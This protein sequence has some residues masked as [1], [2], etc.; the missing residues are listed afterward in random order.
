MPV[1]R[2]MMRMGRER[3]A[4]MLAA[5]LARRKRLAFDHSHLVPILMNPVMNDVV[6]SGFGAEIARFRLFHK[7]FSK[8]AMVTKTPLRRASQHR[9]RKQLPAVERCFLHGS[10]S[11]AFRAYTIE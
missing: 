5:M 9:L 11:L 1:I 7:S 10:A 6:D 4:R 8:Q 3:K 2:R